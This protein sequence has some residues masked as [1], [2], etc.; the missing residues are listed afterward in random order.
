MREE[1]DPGSSLQAFQQK[2]DDQGGELQR[3][4]FSLDIVQGDWVLPGGPL[5]RIQNQVVFH[6]REPFPGRTSM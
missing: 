2:L 1:G 4:S 5:K 3:C 6:G